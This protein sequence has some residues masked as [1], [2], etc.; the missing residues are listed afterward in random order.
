MVVE[1]GEGGEDEGKRRGGAQK[2][3]AQWIGNRQRETLTGG[4]TARPPQYTNEPRVLFH[5]L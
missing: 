2:V 5:M 4:R 1:D 3:S